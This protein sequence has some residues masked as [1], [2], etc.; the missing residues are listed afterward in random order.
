MSEDRS[1]RNSVFGSIPQVSTARTDMGNDIPLEIVP[2]PSG[3]KVYSV[4]S[5]LHGRETLEIKP[6]T[7]REEDIL[8]SRALIKKGTVINELVKSCVADKGID[9]SDLILGDRAAL[10]V[11]IRITGYGPEYNGELTCTSCDEKFSHTFRLDDLPIKTLD[12]KPVEEGKNEFPFV[13]PLSKKT[14]HFKFL[15][16]HDEADI[17]ATSENKKKKNLKGDID[18]LVTSRLNYS[19]V[20]VDGL[21]SKADIVKFVNN[22]RAMDARA[23]REYMDE[24]EPGMEMRQVADCPH[25]GH[26]EEVTVPMGANFFWPSTR[27]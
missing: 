16:G 11:A 18:D 6:M 2:L 25:C 1:D 26:S 9:V 14:V 3:G 19:V 4:D 20:A 27:R 22:M 8:T 21:K 15:T 5:P 10:M 24:K 17:T 12:I 13:L 7:A 23:L